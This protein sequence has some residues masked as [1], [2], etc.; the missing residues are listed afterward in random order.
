M[1]Q[2]FG[3]SCLVGVTVTVIAMF[4]ASAELRSQETEFDHGSL[5]GDGSASSVL[6]DCVACH[7]DTSVLP[8]AHVPPAS[9]SLTECRACHAPE[10]ALSLRGTMPLDHSHALAGVGCT[11][12]HG[13]DD[14]ATMSEPATQVCQ[15][16]H[17]SLDELAAATADVMP[18]N[19]HSSPHGAPY[20]ECSLCH[21]Q[22]EPS[23]NFCASCHDFEFDLP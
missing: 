6:G 10:T 16:C 7:T 5:M 18:T 14:A 4:F 22:H 9:M 21:M 13:N 3:E 2:K 11:S 12:C 20:T 17:G 1:M 19:P 23:Q 8:D 15:A